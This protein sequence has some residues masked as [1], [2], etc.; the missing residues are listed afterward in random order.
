MGTTVWLGRKPAAE[1]G[2]DG[3]PGLGDAALGEGLGASGLGDASGEADTS[4]AEGLGPPALPGVDGTPA[5]PRPVNAGAQPDAHATLAT[6]TTATTRPPRSR[7]V[8]PD[9]RRRVIAR[10]T[11]ASAVRPV[12]CDA[13]PGEGQH[14]R[15]E[16]QD[17]HSEDRL[18]RPPDEAR[19]FTWAARVTRGGA[20][21]WRG[22][23]GSRGSDRQSAIEAERPEAARINS[24]TRGRF[25]RSTL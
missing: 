14:G 6:P 13:N 18:A 20:R 23:E 12:G 22:R 7:R 11:C 15:H 25:G 1:V 19:S 2:A 9:G 3:T 8:A 4:A 10:P 16:R 17:E 5:D 24:P 21:R